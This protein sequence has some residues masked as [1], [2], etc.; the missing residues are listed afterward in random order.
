MCQ[1][2]EECKDLLE[3]MLRTQPGSRLSMGGI[4]AHPW[5]L[6]DLPAGALQVNSRLKVM[7][8]VRC[9][10]PKQPSAPPLRSSLTPSPDAQPNH[11][12]NGFLGPGRQ[13]PPE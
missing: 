10:T 7:D 13:L 4:M 3:R 1:V 6:T 2:S 9:G 5:F 11:L 8:N 12:H